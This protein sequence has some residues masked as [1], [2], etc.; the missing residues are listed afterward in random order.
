MAVVVNLG[1]TTRVTIFEMAKFL[2]VSMVLYMIMKKHY[3][4]IF[5]CILT[6]TTANPLQNSITIT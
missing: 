2:T 5:Q 3:T 1:V 6:G 4:A